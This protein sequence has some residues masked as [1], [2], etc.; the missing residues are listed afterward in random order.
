MAAIGV[1]PLTL[2]GCRNRRM[3][4]RNGAGDRPPTQRPG[5]HRARGIV[6]LGAVLLGLLGLLLTPSVL[7]PAGAADTTLIVPG[8]SLGPARLGMTEQELVAALG[9]AV[10]GPVG[11][12]AFPRWG[13][14]ATVQNG[15][16]VRLSTTSSRFRTSHGA[17]V[18]VRADEAA[19]LVGDQN[20]VVTQTGGE[21]AVLFPFQGVGF[22]FRSGRAAEAFVVER[23]ALG[24]P[25]LGGTAAPSQ[26]PSISAPTGAPPALPV[27]GTRRAGQAPP[28][29]GAG[30]SSLV[31]RELTE[32]VDANSALLRVTGKLANGGV[33]A[34]G[35]MSLAA[36]FS[37][38]SGDDTE[39]QVTIAQQIQPGAE[40][41]FEAVTALTDDLVVRYTIK[42]LAG[43]FASGAAPVQETRRVPLTAYTDLAR[44]RIKVDVQLGGP[45]NTAPMVQAFVSISGT[46]P[47]PSAWVKD[48][49]VLIPFGSSGQEVHL[50]PGQTQMILV[51]AVPLSPPI[52]GPGGT[53]TAGS[54]TLVA[55][56]VGQPKILDV[57]LGAP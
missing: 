12:L 2:G 37:R 10:R 44:Q 8:Q 32:T 31:I 17:G 55:P 26:A 14:V 30:A 13:L 34:A 27:P 25:T 1:E 23:I 45:S 57:T 39:K 24:P 36:T 53:V 16:V 15:F 6:R 51:P 50:A 38:A 52:P 40:A 20:A 47:I 54:T 22:V 28:A 11:K 33:L 7:V 9:T 35:P 3:R 4:T 19:R 56:L 18:G 43:A 41:S 5:R 48:V 21:T 46:S 42:V 49:R 29:T